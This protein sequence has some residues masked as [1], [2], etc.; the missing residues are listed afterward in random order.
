[1]IKVMGLRITTVLATGLIGIGVAVA[2]T[3][4]ASFTVIAPEDWDRAE[5]VV[6]DMAQSWGTTWTAEEGHVITYGVVE[7]VDEP[8]IFYFAT[9][10]DDATAGRQVSIFRYTSSTYGFERLYRIDNAGDAAW[11]VVGYDNGMVVYA[12]TRATYDP[13]ACGEPLVAGV[14]GVDGAALY[15]LPD[16]FAQSWDMGPSAYSAEQADIDEVRTR[17]TNCEAAGTGG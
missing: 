5:S 10:R 14:D 9:K 11:Y 8:G 4:G 15:Q 3:A 2:A 16:N 12:E 17:Q 7:D 1:M 6:G 13:G